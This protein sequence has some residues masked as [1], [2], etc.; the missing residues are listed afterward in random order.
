MIFRK[1]AHIFE[2]MVLALLMGNAWI[3]T[4]VSVDW[5]NVARWCILIG[6]LYAVSD[7]MHQA[8][9]PGRGPSAGDV[10][11]DGLGVILGVSLTPFLLKWVNSWNIK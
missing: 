9:V 1:S 11:I 2:Y 10:M 4:W 7:E 5:G 8:L 3:K 6:L